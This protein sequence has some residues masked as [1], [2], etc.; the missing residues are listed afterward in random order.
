MPKRNARDQPEWMNEEII[1]NIKQR[2][3][4]NKKKR[5]AQDEVEK[6]YWWMQYLEQKQK[7]QRM[8]LQAKSE[9]ENR[10]AGGGSRLT[11]QVRGGEKDGMEWPLY[12]PGGAVVEEQ[13]RNE[14]LENCI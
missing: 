2:R 14:I 10:V 3:K 13:V 12:D 9:Y 7:V 11:N 6:N 1:E 4:Y 8:V 5:H